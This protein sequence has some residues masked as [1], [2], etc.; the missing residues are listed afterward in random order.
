MRHNE[1]TSRSGLVLVRDLVG[2]EQDDR[3]LRRDREGGSRQR[4]RRGA[5]VDEALW[6]SLTSGERYRARILAVVRTRRRMPVV[7]YDSAAALWGYPR[8]SAWPG[9]VHLIADP[10]SAARSKNGVMI[11][12]EGL[13]SADVV[14]LEGIPVTSPQRTLVDLAR[15]AQF[16]DSVSAIDC[17]LSP[18]RSTT[19][20]RV[21]KDQLFE[22]HERVVSPRGGR[23]AWKAIE[24]GNGLAANAGESESRVVIF[25]LGFPD[26]VLQQQHVNPDGGFY[27]TDT[28]WPKYRTIGELDGRG[29][30]LKEEYL[31]SMTPGEAVYVEK[32][33]E[34]HLRAEG[35]S[36][37]RWGIPDIREPGR[38]Q[39]ILTQAGLPIVR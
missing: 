38:L 37:A 7:A 18:V 32:I 35:N 36:F 1:I 10:G 13:D 2:I 33:R 12:R 4:L 27:Y 16:R 25:E 24:F 29:K 28:E 21:T 6:A 8:A 9:A 15:A 11:H 31:G 30:Y 19:D 26:P 23:Q 39:R 14:D 22:A 17:A 5:Y 34:D 20:N 3:P